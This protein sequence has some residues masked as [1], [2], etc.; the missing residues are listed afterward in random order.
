MVAC[1][2]VA[3]TAGVG[4]GAFDDVDSGAVVLE[5]IEVDGGEIAE[6]VAEVA[7]DADGFEKDFGHDDGG[8][9]VE[10]DAAFI[11]AANHFAKEAKVVVGRFAD[12]G[13]VGAGV[14]VRGVGADGDVDG[15]GEFSAVSAVEEAA[16]CVVGVCL[17]GDFAADGFAHA[18]GWIGVVDGVV[19]VA[20]GLFSG[21]ETAIGEDGFDIF[22]GVA[23]DGDFVIVDGGRA[24]HGE[25]VGVAFI[26]EVEEDGGEADFDHVAAE[27]PNDGSLG[28]FGLLQFFRD[29]PE[30]VGGED[31]GEVVEEGGEGRAGGVGFGEH[32][33]GDFAAAAVEGD[34]FEGAEVQGL[35]GVDAHGG[36]ILG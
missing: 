15:D 16:V 26:G 34:G 2:G 3:A 31:S 14:G 6:R 8:S 28:L 13:A 27:A 18:F 17:F 10:I 4:V 20:A 1:E 30:R 21:A 35:E 19:E 33:R 23:G 7:N 22:A 24:V 25:A 29:F 11:E 12:G 9:D 5:E 32:L 36:Y